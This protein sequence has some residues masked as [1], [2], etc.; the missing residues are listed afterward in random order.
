MK[1]IDFRLV[2]ESGKVDS[3]IDYDM[4]P[5]RLFSSLKGVYTRTTRNAKISKS[6]GEQIL[7]MKLKI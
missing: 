5:P 1:V 6:R 3:N 4:I 7:G 2:K